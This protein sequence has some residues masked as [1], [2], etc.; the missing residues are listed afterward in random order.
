MRLP[1]SVIAIVLAGSWS[2]AAHAQ[3]QP[4]TVFPT[5]TPDDGASTGDKGKKPDKDTDGDGIADASEPAAALKVLALRKP[6][7]MLLGD[8]TG[9]YTLGGAELAAAG[10]VAGA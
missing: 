4:M 2:S 3:L 8:G 9:N 5:P 10:G 1:Q 6:T 7:Y